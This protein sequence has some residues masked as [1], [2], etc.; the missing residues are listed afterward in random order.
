MAISFRNV[1][2]S[3]LGD[4]LLINEAVVPAV[5]S[6]SKETMSWFIE[7]APWF[8][9][10]T[11][12]DQ[13]VGIL[14]G[15]YQGASY[16]SENYRWFAGRYS[17]F[18]YVDRVAI[19]NN[20]R[21]QGIATRLYEDFIANIPADIPLLTCEVNTRPA[22]PGSMYFHERLGFEQVGAQE[23]DQGRKAVALLAK[24][25]TAVT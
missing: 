24:R 19:H 12:N 25:L 20:A 22:N 6:L 10:A 1:T 9:V 7:H 3:D 15:F 21:R 2:R 8:R 5:N 17:H 23:T 4:A 16:A 13:V 14:V 11:E 18:A